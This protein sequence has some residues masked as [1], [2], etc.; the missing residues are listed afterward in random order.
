MRLV[1]VVP[2][3]WRVHLVQVVGLFGASGPARA[4]A[5]VLLSCAPLVLSALSLCFCWVAFEYAFIR[6][7]RAFLA[8]FKWFVWVYVVLVLCVACVAFVC[9]NS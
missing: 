3:L 8:R 9:V 4:L 1:R 7:L 6:V 5:L 2:A